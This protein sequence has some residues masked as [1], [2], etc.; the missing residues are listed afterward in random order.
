M[1]SRIPVFLSFAH[2]FWH[3]TAVTACSALD[4]AADLDLHIFSDR[5]DRRWFAKINAKARS[6]NSEVYFHEFDSR[7]VQGLKNC[8][9]YGLSTYYRLFIPDLLSACDQCLVYLDSDLIV[10]GSLHHL[11]ASCE[12]VSLLA[13]V[14][15][16][17]KRAN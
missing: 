12:P 15:G 10:R 8:G 5:F 17:S 14:P 13:A 3:H 16:I 7:R 9:H 4:H 1:N 11:L 6:A 2:N